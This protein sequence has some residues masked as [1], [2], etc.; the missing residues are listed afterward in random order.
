MNYCCSNALPR[1]LRIASAVSPCAIISVARRCVSLG[2]D[3]CSWTDVGY[4]QIPTRRKHEEANTQR[5]TWYMANKQ[6]KKRKKEKENNKEIV[7]YS[8][9]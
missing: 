3:P 2:T 9:W 6:I 5:I 8:S 1:V 7:I 4:L